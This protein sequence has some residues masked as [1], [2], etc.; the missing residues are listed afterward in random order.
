MLFYNKPNINTKYIQKTSIFFEAQRASV[1]NGICRTSLLAWRLRQAESCCRLPNNVTVGYSLLK[2][3]RFID[4][5]MDRTGTPIHQQPS[6][7]DPPPGEEFH[8]PEEGDLS[9][10]TMNHLHHLASPNIHQLSP[11]PTS[12]FSKEFDEKSLL[13]PGNL[14]LSKSAQPAKEPEAKSAHFAVDS[15]RKSE[16]SGSLL[17]THGTEQHL[18]EGNKPRMAPISGLKRLQQQFSNRLYCPFL[19]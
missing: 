10:M 16:A 18:D 6:Q 8:F 5:D 13:S 7:S 19:I 11:E 9:M 17:K 12:E 15:S 14:D 1:H 3:T 4:I 2:A